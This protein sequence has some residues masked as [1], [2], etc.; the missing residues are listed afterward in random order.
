[1]SELQTIET[2]AKADLAAGEALIAPAISSA[3]SLLATRAGDLLIALIVLASI[4]LGHH[5]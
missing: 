1:M 2:T 5:L 4:W 3:R